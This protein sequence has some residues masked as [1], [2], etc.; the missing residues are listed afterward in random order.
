MDGLMSL[1]SGI[2]DD[3]EQ[4]I[5]RY[6][7]QSQCIQAEQGCKQLAAPAATTK[8]SLQ[9][10]SKG[11]LFKLNIRRQFGHCNAI[12]VG[13]AIQFVNSLLWFHISC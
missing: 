7:W 12:M 10:Q 8:R 1:A 6:N 2:A 3:D 5:N 4:E 9:L 13:V 11:K